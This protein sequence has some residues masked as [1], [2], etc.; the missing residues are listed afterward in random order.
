MFINSWM[1][2]SSNDE[3]VQNEDKNDLDFKSYFWYID[4]KEWYHCNSTIN[5]SK[6]YIDNVR[7]FICMYT[8]C[9]ISRSALTW[10]YFYSTY[11]YI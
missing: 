7:I 8:Q 1:N 4:P 5:Y 2:T 10:M 9:I 6:G 11:L 3:E